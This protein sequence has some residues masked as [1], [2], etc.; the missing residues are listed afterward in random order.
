MNFYDPNEK[1]IQ[2]MAVEYMMIK[3][4]IYLCE[5]K[6]FSFSNMLVLFIKEIIII[7][8]FVIYF[9]KKS[10]ELGTNLFAFFPEIWIRT[11]KGLFEYFKSSI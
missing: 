3:V 8:I 5:E 6:N 9:I 7:G 2:M 10:I 1:N 4:I 11:I